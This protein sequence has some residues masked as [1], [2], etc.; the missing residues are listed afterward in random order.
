MIH[1]SDKKLVRK[2]D[3]FLG[4]I[5]ILYLRELFGLLMDICLSER[6]E[7]CTGH[8]RDEGGR[9]QALV[10]SKAEIMNTDAVKV[11]RIA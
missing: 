5:R 4:C 2:D 6:H 7:V 3:L 1:R 9:A 8:D 10:M 11:T